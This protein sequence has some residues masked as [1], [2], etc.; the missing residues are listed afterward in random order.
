MTLVVMEVI[1]SMGLMEI[2]VPG[3]KVFCDDQVVMTYPI[4][5]LVRRKLTNA[6]VLESETCGV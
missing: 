4:S 2:Y 3:V 5:L 1:C 6:V